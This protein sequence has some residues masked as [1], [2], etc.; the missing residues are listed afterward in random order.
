[1]SSTQ[2]IPAD[3]LAADSA[4]WKLIRVH[5]WG[6]S[7]CGCGNAN[8]RS[9]GKHPVG[10]G[11]QE[12]HATAEE[13]ARHLAAGGNVGLLLGPASGVVDVEFDDDAGREIAERLL[14]DIKT[15]TWKSSRSV[16]RLFRFADWLESVE[17]DGAGKAKLDVK[18]LELRL[19]CGGK[20]AQSVMPPSRH[21]SGCVYEWLPGLSPA[22]VETA[23]LPAELVEFIREHTRKPSPQPLATKR[24][25]E[26]SRNGTGPTP[27]DRCLRYL[28]KIEKAIQ[29]AG[30]SDPTFHAACECWK[31]GLSEDAAWHAMNWFNQNRCEPPWSGYELRHKLDSA[32]QD[33]E[34]REQ[35]GCR[36]NE[37]RPE[38]KGGFSAG[39][40]RKPTPEATEAPEAEALESVDDPHRLAR[41]L[42]DEGRTPEGEATLVYWR[43]EWLKWDGAA[44]RTIP[45]GEIRG[46]IT[47]LAKRE[48]DRDAAERMEAYRHRIAS[49]DGRKGE[50]PPK[51]MKVTRAGV[52]NVVQAL[53]AECL[54]SS[55]QEQPSWLEG[56]G[57]FPAEEILPHAGGLL[58]IP[59]LVDGR[60][61]EALLTPQ[62]FASHGLPYGFDPTATC[63]KWLAF[64]GE[65]WPDDPE[66]IEALRQWFGYLLTP[67]TRRHKMA[68]LVG[69]TRCGK[70]TIGRVLL[71]MLGEE[72]CAAPKLS[73]LATS[74]GLWP[75]VG[76]PA[77]L[78]AD[79]RLSG[80]MDGV[81]ILE[82]LLSITGEDAQDIHRKNLPAVTGIKLPTRFTVLTNELPDMRDASGAFS[83]RV[84]LLKLTEDFLGREDEALTDRLKTELP[85]ILNWAIRGWE[86]LRSR[87]RFIQP[88]SGA[89]MLDALRDMG[90][91]VGQFVR[92]RCQVGAG[93]MVSVP[94][95]FG[96]WKEWCQSAGRDKPGTVQTF[97]KQ[98][99]S[100]CPR[101]E[102]A[103][104][105]NDD[106]GRTRH[107][108]GIR[109]RNPF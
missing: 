23:E 33:V 39:S 27:L 64:L 25:A 91:P 1:M 35:F 19:G 63:P 34:A 8:C 14:A 17:T 26:P 69:P 41:L 66:S 47:R 76:K 67:D 87:G 68:M 2:E 96:E 71:A 107:Y 56:E 104:P 3:L 61:C 81:A 51:A 60:D 109:L 84:L 100:V 44:Y 29:G 9:P 83:A 40:D 102:I 16:H 99:S 80:R 53:E 62:F 106:G 70:G 21:A 28:E 72:N 57:P 30:G 55:T 79:A 95:L 97:G 43:D 45:V 93:F 77:A 105:R 7:A 65:L 59:S 89:A 88:A 4:G 48:F 52:S 46:G 90:S 38:G 58:H 11:W 54:L 37:G 13:I 15:P 18:G 31:F 74:F 94:E 73:S 10:K 101:V 78:I 98:L 108:E 82:T 5:G 103:R 50:K 32:R 42:V 86:S 36:L 75:L 12:R 6:G 92:E 24:P 22:E 20:A 85:G 49:G